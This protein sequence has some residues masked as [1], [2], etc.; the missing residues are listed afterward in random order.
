[1]LLTDIVMPGLG[2]VEL[3]RRVDRLHPGTLVIYMSGY[4]GDLIGAGDELLFLQ[5]PFS[6]P[7]LEALLVPRAP[8]IVATP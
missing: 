6:P 5:K 3:G 4:P 7:D 1:V 2:G 8:A